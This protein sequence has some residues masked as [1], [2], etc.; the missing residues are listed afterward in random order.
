MLGRQPLSLIAALILLA[1]FAWERHAESQANTGAAQS[2]AP[3]SLRISVDEVSLTIHATDAHGLPINDLRSSEIS[4]L[5][6]GKPP[7]K[8]LSLQSLQKAPVRGGFLVDV[9]ESMEETRSRDH[10]IA[11]TFA[12]Q[13]L[14]NQ[15]D[16]AFVMNFNFIARITQ[17]WTSD[18]LKLV[19][20]MRDRHVAAV[21]HIR[22]DGTAVFNA[23][24]QACLNQFGHIDDTATGNFILLFSD[25]EDNASLTSLDQ[26]VAMC[27]HTNT[28]IY[29]FRPESK[30]AFSAG[31]KHSHA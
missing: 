30:Y 3:Y 25:G 11:A 13:V 31:P 7:R 4:V 15:T 16:Q 20:A 8:I 21:G 23:L 5:D 19:A 27:Q 9:S 2:G 1:L 22:T 28:S 24:Y 14:R 10:V 17:P 18:P 6:N 29:A 12:Q 26:A